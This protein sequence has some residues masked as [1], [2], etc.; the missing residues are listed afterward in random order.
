[1]GVTI[2]P[3]GLV[4]AVLFCLVFWVLMTARADP[5]VELAIW[6]VIITASIFAIARK[7][8]KG[9]EGSYSTSH[10]LP[11]SVRRW[12]LDEPKNPGREA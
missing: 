11:D 9:G 4:A 5:Y 2:H 10:V 8:L 6:T 3:R 7:L 1:M 12:M